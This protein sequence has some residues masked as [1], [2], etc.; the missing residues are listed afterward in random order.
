M[1]TTISYTGT[2]NTHTV[3]PTQ[4]VFTNN[5][6]KAITLNYANGQ[7]LSLTVGHS[8]GKV[9][10]TISGIT[11]GATKY[12]ADSGNDYTIATGKTVT[13]AKAGGNINMAIP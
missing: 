4:T 10:T 2:P 5:T 9:S 8:S 1:P 6:D 3:K 13:L 11:Y 12:Y 7:S